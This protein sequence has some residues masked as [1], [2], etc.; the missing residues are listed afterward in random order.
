[1]FIEFVK[2]SRPTLQNFRQILGPV[3]PDL[4]HKLQ[5]LRFAHS[6]SAHCVALCR[7]FMH[8][9]RK[10]TKIVVAFVVCLRCQTYAD[11]MFADGQAQAGS[12]AY[13]W[14]LSAYEW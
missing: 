9:R 4:V 1:M 11:D 2:R 6:M 8:R 13:K 7:S 5:L 10:T 14:Q 12:T 3:A